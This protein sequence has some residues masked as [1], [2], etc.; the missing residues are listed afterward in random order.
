MSLRP[1][2]LHEKLLRISKASSQSSV[3]L[4]PK[5]NMSYHE[6]IYGCGFCLMKGASIIFT[7]NLHLFFFLRAL[8]WKT[9]NRSANKTKPKPITQTNKQKQLLTYLD[10]NA[11]KIQKYNLF[12]CVDLI[13]QKPYAIYTFILIILFL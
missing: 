13:I 7:E 2:L 11:A 5:E 12:S 9:R 8:C 3:M 10:L 4:L 6:D 1:Y